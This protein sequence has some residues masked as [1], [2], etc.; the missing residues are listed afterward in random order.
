MYQNIFT[1]EH[2]TNIRIRY[3]IHPL[4]RTEWIFDCSLPLCV[5]VCVWM[6]IREK[7]LMWCEFKYI[8]DFIINFFCDTFCILIF[9]IPEVIATWNNMTFIIHVVGGLA[10]STLSEKGVSRVQN[11]STHNTNVSHR[12]CKG[13]SLYD[14]YL[15]LLWLTNINRH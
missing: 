2:K 6:W 14:L 11:W 4:M 8:I 12:Y 10:T 5:C 13:R 3:D 7:F 9:S 15:L 1:F